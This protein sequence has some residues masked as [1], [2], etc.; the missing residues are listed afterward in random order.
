MKRAPKSPP[1]GPV[2]PTPCQADFLAEVE[3]LL[4][5]LAELEK[6]SDR[7]RHFRTGTREQV[8][9][10]YLHNVLWTARC[11]YDD[12]SCWLMFSWED[13]AA[14]PRLLSLPPPAKVIPIGPHL[15]KRKAARIALK[16]PGER[17][18]RS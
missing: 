8:L 16:D 5:K 17:G 15:E 7:A 9:I 2:A 4:P 1:K 14:G 12:R 11:S 10:H 13:Y 3:A 18:G 6:K